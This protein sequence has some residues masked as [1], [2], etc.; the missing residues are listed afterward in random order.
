[1]MK[2]EHILWFKEVNKK[3][4]LSVGGKGASLGEMHSIMPVPDGFCIT[5]SL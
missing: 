3:D 2:Q 1:M 4:V 5:V